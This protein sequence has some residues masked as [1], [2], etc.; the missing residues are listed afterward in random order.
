[1]AGTSSAQ[2]SDRAYRIGQNKPVF[3]YKLIARG[4]VEE[5]IQHLQ[6][7][8]ATLAQGVLE[9]ASQ[10]QWQLGEEDLQA[11]FQ[12]LFTTAFLLDDFLAEA[13][14]FGAR[15]VLVLSASAKTA[16]SLAHQL[17]RHRRGQVEIV[18]ITSAR[19]A[20]FVAGLGCYDRVLA[21]EAL[22]ALEREPALYVDFAGSSAVR[23]AVHEHLGSELKYACAVG[24]SHG[25]ARP[26][27]QGLPGPKP[28]FFF[29]PE[30]GR[31]RSA[32]WGRE[33]VAARQGGAEA[34]REQTM[35]TLMRCF[36]SQP[37]K[38]STT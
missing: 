31:K 30:S 25:E 18:G 22:A 24:I 8:K 11:L 21:Y 12:P 17:R 37:A 7:A 5:K 2:A 34:S 13:G 6:N 23:A 3:V 32:E 15:R 35:R 20:A 38:P 4:S 16:L 10:G 1:M 28:A 19:H 33:A 26:R 9:G 29:A 36:G 14:F 27:G